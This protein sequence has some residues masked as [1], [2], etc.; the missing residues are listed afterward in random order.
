MA[1]ETSTP[2]LNVFVTSTSDGL[3][4]EV[5]RQLAAKGYTVSAVT[6]GAGGAAQVR[7]DGGLPV[8]CDIFRAGEVASTLKIT[9]ADIII[10]TAPQ[11]INTF[12]PQ[13]PDWD[14][15]QRLLTEGTAALVDGAA[16]AG[17]KFLVHTSYA[18]LYGN[19]HGEAADESAA[20]AREDALFKAAAQA[21][22]TVLKGSVPACV[23][24][25][26]YLY[27][28][29]SAHF[30]ALRDTLHSGGSLA[31]GDDHAVASWVHAVDLANACVLAAEQQPAGE[32]FNITDDQPAAPG[33]FADYFADQYGVKRPG[34]QR[35]PQLLAQMLVPPTQRAL[36]D[37][38]VKAT[39]DK[40]KAR[41]GWQPK[42]PGYQSGLEQILLAW[43]AHS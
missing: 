20:L 18:F 43:R 41:L 17:A 7:Q 5:T 34:R 26:G 23:L 40:A 8:Y 13:N 12:A 28:A 39:N 21:E 22:Q 33:T 3:G 31:L 35:V 4:R 2:V 16:Q 42:Y 6:D 1:E 19:K 15:Y 30:T 32:I 11:G 36:T 10:H 27:G 38:S 14:Y 24:R 29:E 9:Q 25:A 37:V